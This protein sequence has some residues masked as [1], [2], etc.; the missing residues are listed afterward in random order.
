M[1]FTPSVVE[2]PETTRGRRGS[3]HV[4]S[5]TFAAVRELVESRPKT[6]DGAHA[7]VQVCEPQ[8]DRIKAGTVASAYKRMLAKALKLEPEKLAT[9]IAPV[10]PTDPKTKYIVAV[11]IK[12]G[13]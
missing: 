1:A 7:F 6:T 2:L 12:T 5:D 11:A 9:R 10:D 13:A 4:D 8:A 3:K